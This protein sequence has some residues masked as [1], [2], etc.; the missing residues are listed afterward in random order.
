MV[1]GKIVI[2]RVENMSRRQVTFSKRRGGLLKK[3]RELA[4]LCNVQV[5]VI[6][7]SSTCRLYEYA[8]ST[9]A[10]T[11]GTAMPSMI[12]NY[13]SSQEQHQL[14]NPV[15][16]VMFWQGEVQKLQ[17]EMQM[18]QEHH[19][20]LMGERLLNLGVKDL[21]LMENQLEK[22]LHRIREKKEQ[23]STNHILQL[24]EKVR[25]YFYHMRV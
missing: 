12:Q 22:S 14:L 13:Q 16:Q 25:Q 6:V 21:C 23:S 1:R 9:T 5:G 24:N 18:L 20:K 11:M 4:I 2:R 7:F 15:S 3:A 10:T 19:R 17:Q 8:N